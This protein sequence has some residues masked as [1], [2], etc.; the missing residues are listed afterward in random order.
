MDETQKHN[1]SFTYSAK[2]YY[3][4]L[5]LSL[6]S[7]PLELDLTVQKPQKDVSWTI[8]NKT[9]ASTKKTT[10]GLQQNLWYCTAHIA[11]FEGILGFSVQ[12]IIIKRGN[13]RN[14]SKSTSHKSQTMTF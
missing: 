3:L 14:G 4:C 7:L 11:N 13:K 5:I 12:S 1:H 6:S 2:Y 8:Q 9:D 10:K